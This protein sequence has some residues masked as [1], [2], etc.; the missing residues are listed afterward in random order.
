MDVVGGEDGAVGAEE[1]EGGF[2]AAGDADAGD[3]YWFLR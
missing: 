1:G 2:E 3:D